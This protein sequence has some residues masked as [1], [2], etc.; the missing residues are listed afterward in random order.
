PRS[1]L[2]ALICHWAPICAPKSH[3]F[4]LS[5]SDS[6]LRSQGVLP[7][8]N[9]YAPRLPNTVTLP[10]DKGLLNDAAIPSKFRSDDQSKSAE[11]K[12]LAARPATM[13][14]QSVGR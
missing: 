3:L 4:S 12:G 10:P 5:P 9:A 13:V 1:L 2:R 6:L 11:S 14:A 7:Y 8:S